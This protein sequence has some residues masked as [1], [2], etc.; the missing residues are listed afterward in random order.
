MIIIQKCP[1]TILFTARCILD[2]KHRQRLF[3]H[4]SEIGFSEAWLDGTNLSCLQCAVVLRAQFRRNSTARLIVRDVNYSLP[5]ALC[6]KK[7]GAWL[8]CFCEILFKCLSVEEEIDTW[9]S[10][11]PQMNLRSPSHADKKAHKDGIHPVFETKTRCHQ[12][13]KTGVSVALQEGLMSFKIKKTPVFYLLSFW[14]ENWDFFRFNVSCQFS[15]FSMPYQ[16]WQLYG[17]HKQF[18]KEF[19]RKCLCMCFR[20]SISSGSI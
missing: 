11:S 1:D 7:Q 19:V 8:C 13:S 3:L 20:C 5:L 12:K 4:F 14:T 17:N 6:E 16:L 2:S 18:L 9:T 15:M 10:F